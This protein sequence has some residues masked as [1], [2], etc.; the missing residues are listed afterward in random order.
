MKA[1]FIFPNVTAYD[2]EKVD[3]LVGETFTI[4]LPEETEPVEFFFNNDSVLEITAEGT[5]A[6]VKAL[7]G[8]DCVIKL[9]RDD[10][11]LKKLYISVYTKQAVDLNP[12]AGT[13]VLKGKK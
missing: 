6:I 12:V 10:D 3:V 11:V 2:V 5:K 4:N 7:S 1:N 13:P 8:G 9:E